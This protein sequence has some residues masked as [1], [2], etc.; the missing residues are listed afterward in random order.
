MLLIPF[1]KL[2][3]TEFIITEPFA[4][5]QHWRQPNNVYNAIGKPKISHTLLW[6]KNCSA[7][8]TDKNGYVLHCGRNQLAFMSKSSEY[9]VEFINTNTDREDTVVIHFS[10]DR[11]PRRGYL[12]HFKA[13]RLH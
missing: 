1:E 6:F 4:K 12:P 9:K 8:I 5:A 10:N 7:I 13:D 11:Y 3:N 2:Y